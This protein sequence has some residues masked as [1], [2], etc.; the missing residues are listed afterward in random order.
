MRDRDEI[1]KV[2]R[3]T[4]AADFDKIKILNV[5]VTDEVNSDDEAFLRI[6]V[7]F[8]GT[9]KDLDYKKFSRA[10]RFVRPKLEEMG[11][12]AFPLF[13]FISKRDVGAGLEPA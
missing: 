10:V 11:E 8:E 13:S 2:V 4:L 9:P 6:E 5:R 3:S 1:A 7:V 12:M